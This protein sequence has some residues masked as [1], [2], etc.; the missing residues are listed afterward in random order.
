MHMINIDADDDKKAVYTQKKDARIPHYHTSLKE[1]GGK[2]SNGCEY[3]DE[4]MDEEMGS[5]IDSF[6]PHVNVDGGAK[7]KHVNIQGPQVLRS[8]QYY[9]NTCVCRCGQ[10]QED[11]GTME[12]G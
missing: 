6:S 9:Q 10:M 1:T 7:I 5:I 4:G 8:S 11:G 12:G 2:R 3:E